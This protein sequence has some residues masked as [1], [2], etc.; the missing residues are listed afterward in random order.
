MGRSFAF[1]EGVYHG[2]DYIYKPLTRL[3]ILLGSQPYCIVTS[4]IIGTGLLILRKI[5]T[6]DMKGDALTK[7][8]L[9]ITS[10]VPKNVERVETWPRPHNTSEREEMKYTKIQNE[11]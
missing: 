5:L 10:A 7:G 6:S 8:Y 3:R 4:I 1:C 11:K 2:R 9:Q